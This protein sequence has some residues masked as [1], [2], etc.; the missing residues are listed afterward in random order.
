MSYSVSSLQTLA[1][2]DAMLILANKEKAALL[3]KQS[4]L[5]QAKI[6]YQTNSVEAESEL[7]SVIG[8][9]AHLNALIPTLI[10]GSS[11]KKKWEEER[12]KKES[13]LFMLTNKKE[14]FG[15][16]AMLETE[17]ELSGVEF[18]LA[19]TEAFIVAINARKAAL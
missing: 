9:L 15:T 6:R 10:D 13:R 7:P 18:Q 11:I 2:C 17:L 4:V 16:Y 1:D 3:S 8:D 14:G 12:R 19:E 5:E